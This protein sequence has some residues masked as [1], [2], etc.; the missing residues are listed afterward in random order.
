MCAER[1]NRFFNP[2][3]DLSPFSEVLLQKRYRIEGEIGRGGMG[4]VYRAYDALLERPVAIKVLN[5]GGLRSQDRTRLL[6]E[7]QAAAR[8]NHPNIVTIYDAGEEAGIPFIIMELIQGTTLREHPVETVKDITRLGIQVCLALEHAHA[9]S[10]IH[11]DLKPENIMLT[12]DPTGEAGGGLYTWAK[13]TDFGL[14]VTRE[15]NRLSEN[16]AITGTLFYL[17][18]ERLQGKEANV[19]SDLFSLGVVLYEQ[20]IHK[21]PF[22]GEN[23]GQVILNLISQPITSLRDRRD[24]IP[25]SLETIV[26]KLLEKEPQNRFASSLEVVR[27]LEG[28]SGPTVSLIPSR[29]TGNLPIQVTSFIGREEEIRSVQDLL[30]SS[31]LVTLMG[32]GGCGKTRLA[33]EAAQ[34]TAAQFPQGAWLV[35]LASLTD[36]TK[37]SKTVGMV[38]GIKEAKDEAWEGLTLETL[39][40]Q[41]LLV[42]LDNCEHLIDA[43]AS[44]VEKILRHCPQVSVLTTSREALGISGESPFRVPSLGIPDLRTVTTSHAIGQYDAVR[45]FI[46]RA[47]AALPGFSLTP[48]NA[49]SVAQICARLDGIPLAIELAAARVALLRVEQISARLDD[50]FRLLT[51]G[52]RSALP[53]QQTL[54]MSMDWSYHLLSQ[55]EQA[56]LRQMSVFSGGWT[57]EAAEKVCL[58]CEADILDQLT[59]LVKRSLISVERKQGQESRFRML[60]I[61]RQYGNEK[62]FQAGESES[63]RARHLDF[64]RQFFKQRHSQGENEDAWFQRVAHEADNLRTAL[65]WSVEGGDLEAGVELAGIAW[66]YWYS[67]GATSE[68]RAWLQRLL[69][70]YHDETHVRGKALVAKGV[71]AWHQGD[72]IEARQSAQQ[73]I[74][75]LKGQGE[76]RDQAEAIHLLGHIVFD[77]RE[78]EAA[79]ELFT[80]SMKLFSDIDERSYRLTLISDLGMVHYLQGN[81]DLARLAHQESLELARLANERGAIAQAMERLADLSRLEGNY[82]QAEWEYRESLRILRDLNY[83]SEVAGVLHNLGYIE[84]NASDLHNARVLLAESLAIQREVGNKQGMVECLFAFAGLSGLEGK[85]ELAARLFGA[86]ESI[87]ERIG[88][89]LPPAD[90]AEIERYRQLVLDAL[91]AG[92][93]EKALLVGRQLQLEQAIELC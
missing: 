17:A 39:R 59:S 78:F 66:Y 89:P 81:Y 4:T 33:L 32:P 12:V 51:G 31:R 9:H 27:A 48:E 3:E 21:H 38:L 8:L 86:A 36:S 34:R 73:G 47:A 82:K 10:V 42:V 15:G 57:L 54:R 58:S 68:G 35:E 49:A 83:R 20:L 91:G 67:S 52:S 74:E 53:R 11:R 5:Q 13:L 24:D 56:L 23:P 93:F 92:A 77:Q 62:L 40:D 26:V 29:L 30:T 14:A 44:L 7:A 25:D 28:L 16:G 50:A 75:L 79:K 2:A 80:E 43:S 64:Y 37:L 88:A 19:Q 76:L 85:T 63:T 18:P 65:E 69:E 61:I 71:L 72:Y 60:E 6:R 87:L 22:E 41:H 46:E 84:L 45:L 1:S 70:E 90:Q 55:P